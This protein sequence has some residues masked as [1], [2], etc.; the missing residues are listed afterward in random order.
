MPQIAGRYTVSVKL[1]DNRIKINDEV[2][3]PNYYDIKGSP[4]DLEV[5]PGEISPSKSFTTVTAEAISQ[6]V[7]GTTYRFTTQLVDIYGILLIGGENTQEIEIRANYLN[8]DEWPSPIGV[9][10]MTDWAF[11]YGRDIIGI[12]S[13]NKDGSYL[14]QLTIYRAGAF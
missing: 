9:A 5:L 2:V 13:N 1:W 7:A 3:T 11:I 14:S 6:M 10:D 8:H 12:S 4:F